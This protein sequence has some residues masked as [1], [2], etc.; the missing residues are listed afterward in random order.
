[1]ETKRAI[2]AVLLS[3]IILVGYQYFLVPMVT[4]VVDQGTTS[5]SATAEQNNFQSAMPVEQA[6]PIAV[7]QPYTANQLVE[8][9]TTGRDISVETARF[10]AVLSESGGGFKSFKLKDYQKELTDEPNPVELITTE[11]ASEL[12]L[13]FSWGVEPER[14]RIVQ[15]T[16]HNESVTTS[17][18]STATLTMSGSLPSGIEITR[19]MLFDDQDY[20]MRLQIEVRNNSSQSLQGAPFLRL[21]NRP[22]SANVN[23]VFHGPAAYIDG[24][25]QEIKPKKLAEASQTMQGKVSWVAYESTYFMCGIIPSD[26]DSARLLLSADENEK[27]STVLSSDNNILA[28]QE[29]HRYEYTIYFG[30]KKLDTLKSVGNDLEKIID[31]GWFDMMA[32]PTLF[33][34]KF[35]YKYFQNY[36]FAIILVTIIIKLIFWPISHKGMKSMK[37]MQKI[38]PKMAKLREKYKEDQPRLNEEMMK[39]YKTYKINPLG[40]CLPMVLQ[41]PVFFALYKVLLQTIELRHA[42]F[43]LWIT[44]LSAPDRLYLG[45]H[46]PYLDGLPVLTLLMGGSMFLQQKMTPNSG[47]P[48]QAKMML[49][50]PVIFTFMFINF[51]SGLV[52]YWFLN[53]LL[54]MLQQYVINRQTENEAVTQQ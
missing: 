10:A 50:L 43:M 22:I 37:N 9:T 39:L 42:P 17:P 24:E 2:V 18:D 33:L 36:G 5:T 30:P 1:M 21:V 29:S 46:I 47:D 51:A 16:A 19:T 20:R 54:S 35:F 4:P 3:L 28:P 44:D 41:I 49:F 8:Q 13:F 40:G 23:R 6:Q 53:N 52:L 32:K 7:P 45:F 26:N 48:T 34:L 25:L 12:P 11:M 15:L 38:Q 31:F 27:V 14:A